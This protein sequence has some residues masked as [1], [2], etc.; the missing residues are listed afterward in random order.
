MPYAR[1]IASAL[2][3]DFVGGGALCPGPGHGPNDRSLR[4]WIGADG[5]PR[6]HS[7]CGD[8]WKDCLD[9]VRERLGRE[10]FAP[11]KQEPH[12]RH[13]ERD[14][15]AAADRLDDEARERAKAVFTRDL[16]QRIWREA[17]PC[18]GTLAETYLHSRKIELHDDLTPR[19][20]RFHPR[21]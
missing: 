2:G 14:R 10:P 16:V 4:V 11:E 12:R 7:F 3:G 20:L 17:G 21:V 5:Q 6:V 18:F 9:Y 1:E 15:K 13:Q 19:V 8:D